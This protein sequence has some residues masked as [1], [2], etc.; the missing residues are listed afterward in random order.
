MLPRVDPFGTGGLY[1]VGTAPPHSSCL[2][3]PTSLSSIRSR[4]SRLPGSRG[5]SRRA[6]VRVAASGQDQAAP[7]HRR[8]GRA[9]RGLHTCP[10]PGAQPAQ[11]N[12]RPGSPQGAS[13]LST[14]PPKNLGS[15][16]LCTP[17]AELL[18]QRH[19]WETPN[20][21]ACWGCRRSRHV[22]Q[23]SL[24]DSPPQ[25]TPRWQCPAPGAMFTEHV[26]V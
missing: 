21:L 16:P 20:S 3:L 2:A 15:S 13:W 14:E 6:G 11:L 23:S 17:L 5:A 26:A 12:P 1:L 18:L 8:P 25:G 22:A 19:G 24:Q 10:G 7:T 4:T 9:G